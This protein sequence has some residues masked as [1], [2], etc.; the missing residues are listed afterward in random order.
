MKDTILL[1]DRYSKEQQ[2]KEK[3][4][5]GYKDFGAIVLKEK[6]L[7]LEELKVV[8]E[9]KKMFLKGDTL[10]YNTDAFKMPTGSVLLELVRH[11]P[12]IHF[13]EY[14]TMLYGD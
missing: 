11:L 9:L 2:S 13:N 1:F 14:G 4:M 12:G 6:T 7:S 3:N 5:Q 10:I 8:G